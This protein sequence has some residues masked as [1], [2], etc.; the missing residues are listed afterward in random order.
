MS[1]VVF[2][3]ELTRFLYKRIL[4]EIFLTFFY[5]K[6]ILF[7]INKEKPQITPM[8]YGLKCQLFTPGTL[9]LLH[10]TQANQP[11]IVYMHIFC[12]LSMFRC[13]NFK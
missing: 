6:K 13:E 9:D 3:I 1:H 5:S 11:V 10:F 2:E 4:H 8:V 12:Y 7:E